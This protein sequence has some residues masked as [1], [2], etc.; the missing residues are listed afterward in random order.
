MDAILRMVWGIVGPTLVNLVLTSGLPAALE[1][2][3]S[4]NL[5]AWLVNGIAG[6]IRAV[7]GEVPT[8]I[9]RLAHK[10][11]KSV[12]AD[13]TLSPAQKKAQI[14]AIRRQMKRDAKAA[15]SGSGCASQTKGLD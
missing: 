6:F 3:K 7:I 15:C 13:P 9:V 8:D 12:K 1:F 5:P 14:A 2:L 10:D 11:I 4:K